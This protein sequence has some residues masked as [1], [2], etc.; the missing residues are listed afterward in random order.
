VKF[1]INDN[2]S[3]RRSSLICLTRLKFHIKYRILIAPRP[4]RTDL[5]FG[6]LKRC[7]AG[8]ETIDRGNQAILYLNSSDPVS[9]A[10]FIRH[11]FDPRSRLKLTNP[12][13]MPALTDFL[14]LPEPLEA[15]P[16]F[17][18]MFHVNI[19]LPM[20]WP[21]PGRN[22]RRRKSVRLKEDETNLSRC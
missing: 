3:C 13:L 9:G 16:N 21:R 5:L 15:S 17:V 18:R 10:H 8:S 11:P 7:R 20:A 14:R 19:L 4:R 22:S 2:D 6:F 12:L 1:H